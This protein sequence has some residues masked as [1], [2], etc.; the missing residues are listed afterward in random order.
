MGIFRR[1]KCSLLIP[2]LAFSLLTGCSSFSGKSLDYGTVEDIFSVVDGTLDNIVIDYEN[3]DTTF[4]SGYSHLYE[5]YTRQDYV[6]TRPTDFNY[7]DEPF[8][9]FKYAKGIFSSV[10]PD[11]NFGTKYYD[12]LT[13]N[14]YFDFI[15]GQKDTTLDPDYN[16]LCNSIVGTDVK[17]NSFNQVY[18]NVVFQNTYTLVPSGISFT[19]N[20]Y[21]S[22]VIDYDFSSDKPTFILK[23]YTRNDELNAPYVG[24]MTYQ[25][26]YIRV[27]NGALAEYRKFNVE[28]NKALAP[29][30]R[31]GSFQDFVNEGMSYRVDSLKWYVD[32]SYYVNKNMPE[33]KQ[34]DIG[35][36]LFGLGMFE[37][38]SYATFLSNLED[39]Q[40]V[41]TSSIYTTISKRYGDDIQY[42]FLTKNPS[43]IDHIKESSNSFYNPESLYPDLVD[44]MRACLS[45]LS[46]IP[47]YSV[48]GNTTIKSLFTNFEDTSTMTAVY[49]PVFYLTKGKIKEQ[50][51][52]SDLHNG[53]IFDFYFSVGLTDG[54]YTSP[55]LI[56]D[57]Y[58][59]KAAFLKVDESY[60]LDDGDVTGSFKID[61]IDKVKSLTDGFVLL[62]G[63]SLSFLD[64]N[65]IFPQELLDYGVPEYTSTM[66][67]QYQLA[68]TS[69]YKN[70]YGCAIIHTSLT[71]LKNYKTRLTSNGFT[72]YYDN[73]YAGSVTYPTFLY[74]KAVGSN[75]LLFVKL[76]RLEN[77]SGVN[78]Y[79]RAYHVYCSDKVGLT[80]AFPSALTSAGLPYYSSISASFD[81]E[82]DGLYIY[83]SAYAE[84]HNYMERL[85]SSYGYRYKNKN[86]ADGIFV[87]INDEDT[88]SK[89][90]YQ[91]TFY[92][93]EYENTDYYVK[94]DV[95]NNPN[96]FE[97]IKITS[98]YLTSIFDTW[99]SSAADNSAAFVSTNPSQWDLAT[100]TYVPAGKEFKFIANGDWSVH[101]PTTTY[102][103]FGYNDVVGISGM[104][105]Y[106]AKGSNGIIIAK[107][108]LILAVSCTVES[109][110]VYFYFSVT[111]V[112]TF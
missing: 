2:I 74:Q 44:E 46:E 73:S 101:N 84:I 87:L 19:T 23:T 100:Q 78:Y 9:Q 75:I 85:V 34:L 12:T 7:N 28:T 60:T 33:S 83:D 16:V 68:S 72:A 97:G 55:I 86:T 57:T 26:D 1:K 39:N 10:G 69:T 30:E 14:V 41:N 21:V 70:G 104:T 103:G 59:I 71:D 13:K 22:F 3:H 48:A 52:S 31:H 99:N 6:G 63:D 18:S 112:G 56:S 47:S 106:F 54:N 61:I 89:Y 32:G 49:V 92:F 81:L 11:F 20:R 93:Y 66:V 67:T 43:T 77:G 37:P 107:Q 65:P 27:I 51:P 35:E 91:L 29:D 110:Y 109:D 25:Y 8:I 64:K 36:T 90:I 79:L 5:L 24:Y 95:S 80:T 76:S 53:S 45:D 88:T 108:A 38:L 98:L 111:P 58:S 15:S 42:A 102:P 62:Y 94:L 105:N 40:S 50:I 96:Y 17:V 4:M 82:S